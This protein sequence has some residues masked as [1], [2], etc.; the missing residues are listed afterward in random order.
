MPNAGSWFWKKKKSSALVERAHGDSI[1]INQ[2]SPEAIDEIFWKYQLENEYIDAMYL[3]SHRVKTE[4]V[5]QYKHFIRL[6]LSKAGKS[7]YLTK[8]NN[9]ILRIKSLL[10]NTSLKASY[11]FA[12]R[13]PLSHA[14]SL[15]KQ[16]RLFT[17]MHKKDSF[18]L[19]YFNSMGHHEFGMNQKAFC[20]NDE[21]VNQSFD[22]LDKFQLDYWLHTWLNYH[23]FLLS[24]PNEKLIFVSFDDICA[25]PT[26]IMAQVV[27]TCQVKATIQP[28]RPYKAPNYHDLNEPYSNELLADCQEVYHKLKPRCLP[29]K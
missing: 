2:E 18:S 24:L 5:H 20:F 19:S 8:N 25:N 17:I 10:E 3:K 7:V 9:T 28:I 26:K 23:R 22:N 12:L 4:D 29:T 14:I 27:S 6:H 16:H 21:G 13:D 1:L 11:I 15:L